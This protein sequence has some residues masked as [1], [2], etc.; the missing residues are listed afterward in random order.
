MA[1]IEQQLTDF[2]DYVMR[3]A[4]NEIARDAHLRNAMEADK[5]EREK[6]AAVQIDF[7]L[8]NPPTS[9]HSQAHFTPTSAHSQAH[10][11]PTSAHSQA[12]LTPTSAHSQAHLTPTSAQSQAHHTPDTPH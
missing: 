1:T 6:R 11:T 4:E 7:N 8:I 10:L 5:A 3:E 9:A 2:N 12:H